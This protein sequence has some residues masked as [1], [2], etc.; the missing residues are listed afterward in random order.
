MTKIIELI[1]RSSDMNFEDIYQ[2]V[3]KP[4]IPAKLPLELSP[5]LFDKD[6]IH[7]ISKA[8]NAMGAYRGFLINIIN[9]KFLISPLISQEAVLSSTDTTIE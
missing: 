8:N 7:L 3:P 4:H 5:I 6:I 1:D 9:P 2:N